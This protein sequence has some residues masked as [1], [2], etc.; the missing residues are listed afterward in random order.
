MLPET[1][2]DDTLKDLLSKLTLTKGKIISFDT[3]VVKTLEAHLPLFNI[4]QANLA[5]IVEYLNIH[6]TNNILEQFHTVLTKTTEGKLT[7]LPE[8]VIPISPQDINNITKQNEFT[9][10]S[11]FQMLARL[12]KIERKD[13][14]DDSSYEKAVTELLYPKSNLSDFI[15]TLEMHKNIRTGATLTGIFANL[16]K[17]LAYSMQALPTK[18]LPFKD[19]NISWEGED[20]TK[21]SITE[22]NNKAKRVVS[23]F[24]RLDTFT[25]LAIDNVKELVLHIVGL[26]PTN[27]NSFGVLLSFGIPLNDVVL[28]FKILDKYNEGYNLK[29]TP[30]FE[31]LVESRRKK[32]DQEIEDIVKSMRKNFPTKLSKKFLEDYYQGLITDENAKDYG[33]DS[34]EHIEFTLQV[35]NVQVKSI[36]AVFRS[37]VSATSSLRGVY[38]YEKLLKMLKSAKEVFW[39]YEEDNFRKHTPHIV[40][41]ID[42]AKDLAEMISNTIFTKSRDFKNIMDKF[43]KSYK[44]KD[45]INIWEAIS[46]AIEKF[47]YSAS[48]IYIG[49]VMIN[50]DY[51]LVTPVKLGDTTYTGKE[52]WNQH[53]LAKLEK[54]M[55][56]STNR[57]KYNLFNQFTINTNSESGTRYISFL[58]TSETNGE[59]KSLFQN[60]FRELVNMDIGGALNDLLPHNLPND[61]GYN[62][63]QLAMF[64][65]ATNVDMTLRPNSFSLVLDGNLMAAYSNSIRHSI[66][67]FKTNFINLAISGKLQE[68]EMYVAAH[69]LGSDEITHDKYVV[70]DG[71]LY[72]KKENTLIPLISVDVMKDVRNTH[73]SWIHPDEYLTTPSYEQHKGVTTRIIKNQYQLKRFNI[74]K[75]NVISQYAT[76]EEFSQS[77]N[78]NKVFLTSDHELKD[79]EGVLYYDSEDTI[80]M[81][82]LKQ[83]KE[84]YSIIYIDNVK[85]INIDNPKTY[86]VGGATYF[87]INNYCS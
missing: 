29:M 13:Y 33:Y 20:I 7:N 67:E 39:A 71:L 10:E 47:M 25:N 24:E 87:D 27:T 41:A 32:E 40:S 38:E 16:Y 9:N 54:I 45:Y 50:P 15:T 42:A 21:F 83:L 70:E 78:T 44:Y 30:A 52:A 59:T 66:N 63:L 58:A 65:Y 1:L 8:L 82:V 18:E 35:F 64:L 31:A 62:K 6:H 53:F 80:P 17:V 28:L 85:T 86:E 5:V 68:L 73:M 51:N 57:A 69:V 14:P 2:G 60:Q 26:T 81:D 22:I 12:N 56:K 23:I 49:K 36:G 34:L 11:V 84:S 4:K 43:E 48:N 75:Q 76:Y 74:A 3:D 37:F 61:L 46:S 77:V 79:E 19:P 55:S 72:E